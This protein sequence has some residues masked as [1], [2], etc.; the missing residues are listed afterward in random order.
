[1]S[2]I[3]ALTRQVT[4]RAPVP[5][6]PRR[7]GSGLA[8]GAPDRADPEAQMRAYG[9]VSTLFAIVSG[10]N[11]AESQ[12]NWR[13]YRK[14]S[15]GRQED[16]EEVASHAAL[17]LLRRPNPFLSQPEFLEIVAQHRE[18][19]GEEWW[20][21][22]RAAG[23]PIELW[24]VRP[25]RMAPVPD[26]RDFV[27]GY[28]YTSPDGEK[29][30]LPLEDV[31]QVKL[32]NPLDPHR[33]MGPVQSLLADLDAT[34]YS[35]EWNRNFFINGA[36]P[37]GLIEVPHTL[38][39]EDYDQF[40]ARWREQHQGVANAHRVALLEGGMSW[41]E[42]QFTMRDMQFTELRQVSR[43]I[44]REAFRFPKPLLGAVDDVNRANALAAE[45]MFA[46]WLITPRCERRRG[47]LNSRLLPLFGRDAARTLEF[48]F[49]KV[50]PSDPETENAER[51]SRARSAEML[52]SAGY[53]PAAVLEAVG[54]PDMAHRGT[55][56]P[57]RPGAQAA[58]L[59][60]SGGDPFELAGGPHHAH[61][62]HDQDDD[63]ER[64]DPAIKRELD[65]Q[66]G[67]VQRQWEH[68]LG[69]LIS[70]WEEIS[71]TQRNELWEQIRQ[72]IDAG[73]LAALSDLGVSTEQ[74]REL[75]TDAMER[76]A[77][78]SGERV[79]D[80]AESQDVEDVEAA[81]PDRDRLGQI[82]GGVVGILATGMATAAGREA[83]RRARG[84]ADGRE[85]ADAVDEQLRERS[86]RALRDELGGALTAG[87]NHGRVETLKSA[88]SAAYY[89][90]EV[91]DSNTCLAPD[92][93]VT[94]R[95]G[96]V[97]AAQVTLDDELLTHR[98][99]WIHPS[100]IVTSQVEHGRLRVVSA[101]NGRTVRLTPDHP[102][103][104]RTEDGFVWRNAGDLAVGD[105]V[106]GQSTL[107][108]GSEAV[109]FDFGLGQT[110]NS[111]TAIDEVSGLATVNVGPE[112]VPVGTV[113]LDDQSV[114]DKEVAHPWADLGLGLMGVAKPLEDPAHLS[115]DAGLSSASSVAALRAVP[116]S[117]H[118]RGTNAEVHS[119]VST[120]DNDR[121]TPTGLGAVSASIGAG[122]AERSGA[123]LADSV[124]AAGVAACA[125]AVCIPAGSRDAD[126][127]GDA[128]GR[129]DLAD[130]VGARADLGSD[131]R[132]GELALDR[133]VHSA[134]ALP[135][136]D[137]VSAYLAGRRRVVR[138]ETASPGSSHGAGLAAAGSAFR[139]GRSAVHT[140]FV[141]N[142]S[143]Q[144]ETCSV[145]SVVD[146]PYS[147]EVYDFTIPGDH[148]FW[149]EGVLVHNCGPCR[150]VD[151]RWLGNAE[152]GLD[153]V[154]RSYPNGGYVDCEGG[155]RCRGTVVSV[156][157]PEQVGDRRD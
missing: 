26:P 148:T 32:P 151:G 142:L 61:P 29:I 110:P 93:L 9:A 2:L 10:L 16:R 82:A 48:D 74:A 156:W 75:L 46:R 56:P 136:R 118:G 146:T 113:G 124:Y 85:V 12:V 5:Y 122:V 37:G 99:R 44:I 155:V 19:T 98:G 81:E 55:P 7:R 130:A 114:P 153:M 24:P 84:G 47:M 94:T 115:L 91:N 123:S 70:D 102:V 79:A 22:V 77:R 109:T 4:N 105:L 78:L 157:R 34:R 150:Q 36:S 72:A 96:E 92:A 23:M 144:V 137:L 27:V 103:L 89:A 112:G 33:G 43:E 73:D 25:D 18:L 57:S 21:V 68:H 53:D 69:R 64:L 128:A 65:E 106:V 45:V 141:H 95:R 63:A 134:G 87:Q 52:V 39:D 28:T 152:P 154:Q 31:I 30:P 145:T 67:E 6:T 126:L 50:T 125:G 8:S 107:E 71:R 116:P 129:A 80:E 17:D 104:V 3:G 111:E 90:S 51:D 149:A 54:L 133:A 86:D 42:R 101:G 131:F 119:A 143:V 132:V 15:S 108:L 127:E 83:L 58:R 60:G 140:R 147:G 49:D 117:S 20:V 139:D 135:A 120:A 11:E 100:A 66:L 62:L 59:E 35:A 97:P 14:A 40:T 76:V 38:S 13:L 121:R 41:K 88:P 1:M 138:T